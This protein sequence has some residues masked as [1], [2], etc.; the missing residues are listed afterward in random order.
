ME[1]ITKEEEKI[2]KT[3]VD[4]VIE[5]IIKQYNRVLNGFIFKKCSSI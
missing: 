3:Q 1:E 5:I 4:N 2:Q